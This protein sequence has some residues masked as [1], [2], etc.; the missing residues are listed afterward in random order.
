V[1][2]AASRGRC[3]FPDLDW[4]DFERGSELARNDLSAT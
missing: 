1:R 3:Q 2:Q 4:A